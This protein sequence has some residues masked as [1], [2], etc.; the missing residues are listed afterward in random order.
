MSGPYLYDDGPEALHTGR[1]RSRNGFIVALLGG[2]AAVAVAAVVALPLVK[3][4]AEEQ[5]REVVGVYLAALEA[6]DTETAGELLCEAERDRATE[7]GLAAGERAREYVPFGT[8]EV[9]GVRPGELDGQDAQEVRVRWD[10]GADRA[11]TTLTVVLE[12]GP[13]VCGSSPAG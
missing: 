8:G 13:R 6:G 10:D 1:P 5:A 3:G 2:T 9:V 4:S 11:E 7:Q 12:D